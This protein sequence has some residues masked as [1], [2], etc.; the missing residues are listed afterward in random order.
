MHSIDFIKDSKVALE[1]VERR[2][3]LAQI[4]ARDGTYILL[5]MCLHMSNT[6]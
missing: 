4:S 1:D 3:S 2:R 6:C 5:P